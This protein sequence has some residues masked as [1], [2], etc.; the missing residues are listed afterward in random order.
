MAFFFFI[1]TSAQATSASK[2]LANPLA[3]EL[4]TRYSIAGNT[5]PD[6]LLENKN[7]RLTLTRVSGNNMT[8]FDDS[9]KNPKTAN[10]FRVRIKTDDAKGSIYAFCNQ[11]GSQPG[12]NTN[13]HGQTFCDGLLWVS[14]E[15]VPKILTGD[16]YTK[17]APGKVQPNDIVLYRKSNKIIHS[18]TVKDVKKG[19]VK[20]WGE[21]GLEREPHTNP[22]EPGPGGG[23]DDPTVTFEYW[24]KHNK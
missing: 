7:G 18:M 6:G 12:F 13:C 20:V 5:D 23:W 19:K 2:A 1:A 4:D 24:H 3:T 9:G 14:D 11:D 16:N 21:A 10:G 22:V 8:I 17:I 15:Q